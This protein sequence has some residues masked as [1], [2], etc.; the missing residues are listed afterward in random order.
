MNSRIRLLLSIGLPLLVVLVVVT[1]FLLQ[2]QKNSGASENSHKPLTKMTLALDWTPNTNHTGIYVAL[3]KQNHWYA[4]EGI[5]LQLLPYSQSILPDTL[6]STGK[7]DVG[8][9]STEAIVA[10][11]AQKQPVVSIAAIVQHNTSALVTL[12]SSGITNL[13]ELDGKTYGAFGYPYESAVVSQ[14][15]KHSGGKGDFKSVTVDDPMQALENHQVDFAWVFEGAEGIQAKHQGIQLNTFPIIENGIADYY[16]P[17][18]ITSSQEIQQKSDLLKRFMR[19]TARGYEYARTH[20]TEAA[21]DLLQGTPKGTFPDEAYVK[22]SQQ[23]L[24]SRYADSGHKWGVQ[25]AAAWHNYPQFILDAGGVTDASNQPVKG[26][27]LDAL[28]TNQFLP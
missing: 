18:I 19:A 15:I 27:E 4:D 21:Q 11:A 25:E 22:E 13:K 7:A 20:V 17:T 23:F 12:A 9:S 1:A 14:M 16:T 3:A 8:I 28:Y 6:V 5:D 2:Q 26:L 24:S 10:D